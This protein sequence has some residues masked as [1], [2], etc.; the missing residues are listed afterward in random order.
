VERL[1]GTA[2]EKQRLR[3]VLETLSGERSVRE[4][5]ELLGLSEARFHQLRQAAL[6]GALAGLAPSPVGR[7]PKVEPEESSRVDELEREVRDLRIDLQAARVRTE[8]A[9]TM[10]HLLRDREGPSKK[11]RR[12]A[13]ARRGGR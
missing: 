4:A 9:L 10:P 3:L 6:E 7:P 8:I 5:S 12:R 11:N 2:E 1:R 13:K